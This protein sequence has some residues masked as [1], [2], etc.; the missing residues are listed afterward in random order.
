[1]NKPE[2]ATGVPALLVTRCSVVNEPL[3][4]VFEPSIAAA[5][6]GPI[7]AIMKTAL[8]RSG[9]SFHSALPPTRA[10]CFDGEYSEG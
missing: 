1:M 4:P 6:V 10:T 9:G 8:P 2:L 5:K 7:H 3:P